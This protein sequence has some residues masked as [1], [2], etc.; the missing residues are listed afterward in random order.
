MLTNM[1]EMCHSEV[2][3][4]LGLK[5]DAKFYECWCSITFCRGAILA[6]VGSLSCKAFFFNATNRILHN[7]LFII[8][9]SLSVKM[10][11]WAIVSICYRFKVK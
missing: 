2:I 7:L 9:S 6:K 10:K 8:Q 3:D 5:K 1:E 11:I 4:K